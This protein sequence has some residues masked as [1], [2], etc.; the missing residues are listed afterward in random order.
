M[1]ETVAHYLQ[2]QAIAKKGD[3][4]IADVFGR[5]AFNRYYYAMFL[6]ARSMMATL[7]SRWGGMPHKQ[8]PELLKGQVCGRFKSEVR[9]A[10]K[11]RDS[12][13]VA[14]CKKAESACH[15]LADMFLR[16]YAIRVVA[17]YEPAER[18]VF[19]VTGRFELR[20]VNINSAHEWPN[21]AD[22]FCR[23]IEKTWAQF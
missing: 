2:Q 8:Y 6:R 4:A 7:D 12:D 11:L 16:S 22:V 9:R 19:D 18:V 21:K 1:L 17:D 15:G 23:Y 13:L 5:S 3:I 20:G 10:A 14:A